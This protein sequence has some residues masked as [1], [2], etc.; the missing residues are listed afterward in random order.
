MVRGERFLILEQM[1]KVLEPKKNKVYK[2][3]GCEPS[4]DIDVK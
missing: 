4:D 2:F 1:M 3:F